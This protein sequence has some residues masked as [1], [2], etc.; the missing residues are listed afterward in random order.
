MGILLMPR[1]ASSLSCS[2]W[3]KFDLLI[4]LPCSPMSFIFLVVLI[5]YPERSRSGGKRILS[6]HGCKVQPI[7]MKSGQQELEAAS[8]W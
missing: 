6:A 5:I 7:M 2:H 3:F 1:V 8:L 4:I